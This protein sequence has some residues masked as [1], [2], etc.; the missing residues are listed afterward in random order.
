MN[1]MYTLI[2]PD[3]GRTQVL[4]VPQDHHWTLPELRFE[5]RYFWQAVGHINAAVH[6]Q[7]GIKATTL[8]CRSIIPPMPDDPPRLVY[9]LELH[10]FRAA[11]VKRRWANRGELDD[12]PAAQRPLLA[13]WW[14]EAAQPA[15]RSGGVPW[16]HP[17]WRDTML[18]WLTGALEQAGRRLTGSVEQVRSWERSAL[19]RAPSDQGPVFF[20][21]V[22]PVFGH[23]PALTALLAVR[24]PDCSP[25]ILGVDPARGWLLMADAGTQLLIDHPE[26]ERWE[27]ALGAY[28]RM[29]VALSQHI[30]ELRALGVPERGL[31]WLQTGL[32]QLLADSG[33]LSAGVAGLA[34][35]EIVALRQL[36]PELR[37][38]CLRWERSGLP[39]SL[40]HGDFSAWQVQLDG[41]DNR[42]LD[43]S[44]SSVAPPFFSML[45]IL[46]DLPGEILAVPHAATRL[47]DTYLAA[48][49]ELV[50]PGSAR[51]AFDAAQR[52]APLHHAL[53]YYVDVLPSMEQHWELESM[54]PYYLRML[55][56]RQPDD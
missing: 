30:G 27:A 14:D 31:S 37:L 7:L 40:E 6:E 48:W 22:P 3:P 17:G 52:L 24:F 18:P 11:C 35:D 25:P 9:E 29:Q 19:W 55:L 32:G 41:G 54:L 5:Q 2:I 8:R 10:G 28:A 39:L 51:E 49:T 34:S 50:P 21:A 45:G 12:L 1:P 15:T 46:R 53:I 20:K 36:E 4:L 56:S 47:R 38:D 23:E 43:W 26:I 33:A 42:F 44:D 13:A 16:Y